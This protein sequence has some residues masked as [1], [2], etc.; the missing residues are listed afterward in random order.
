MVV[1]CDK[2]G[3]TIWAGGAP[4]SFGMCRSAMNYA[5]SF[6]GISFFIVDDE[7][8]FAWHSLGDRPME[9]VHK[10]GAAMQHAHAESAGCVRGRPL[11]PA[12]L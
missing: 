8:F 2:D 5:H 3:D 7:A 1:M 4:P 11:P 12:F 9:A 6:C 10:H